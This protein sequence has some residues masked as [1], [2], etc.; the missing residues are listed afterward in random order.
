MEKRFN[1][2]VYPLTLSW[3]HGQQDCYQAGADYAAIWEK[4]CLNLLANISEKSV[5]NC[6]FVGH[7]LGCLVFLNAYLRKW[8]RFCKLVNKM[9]FFAPAI[10]FRWYTNLL[11]IIAKLPY[12]EKIPIKTFNHPQYRVHCYTPIIMYKGLFRTQSQLMKQLQ[13]ISHLTTDCLIFI[14]PHDELVSSA[15]L[16]KLANTFFSSHRIVKIK[17]RRL[18]HHLIIDQSPQALSA[19]QWALVEKEI[20]RFIK[21][22]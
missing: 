17:K 12:S 20:G 22:S 16:A 3:H 19:G 1:C 8:P 18:F 2:T 7:S 9:I 4:E 13:N 11:K 15:K 10:E 5:G 6:Y 14:D 21:K